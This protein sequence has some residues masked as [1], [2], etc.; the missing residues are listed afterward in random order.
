MRRLGIR[1]FAVL[2]MDS[3][4][5]SHLAKHGFIGGDDNDGAICIEYAGRMIELMQ[6][7]E[8]DTFKHEV[9]HLNKSMHNVSKWATPVHKIMINTKLYAAL[10]ALECQLGV[11]VTD[12]DIV[13]LEDP[14]LSFAKVLQED[15]RVQMVFQDDTT[16]Q[17][18]LSLNSGFFYMRPTTHNAKFMRAVIEV[19][20]QDGRFWFID[21]ARVN[22]LLA[23]GSYSGKNI[24]HRLPPRPFPNGAF[25]HQMTKRNEQF[26]AIKVDSKTYAGVVKIIAVHANWSDSMMAKLK[27]LQ[28]TGIWL[29]ELETETCY[30]GSIPSALDPDFQGLI[31]NMGLGQTAR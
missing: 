28:N 30:V 8:P 31:D 3:Y 9:Q 4:G 5:C 16:D 29:L 7:Y 10:D 18:D 2:A 23:N 15:P 27:M 17:F 25:I 6:R 13:F 12:A 19:F 11:F 22:V 26:G 21:Q 14:M 24:W 20:G 1:H